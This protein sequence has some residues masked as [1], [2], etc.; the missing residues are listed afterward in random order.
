MGGHY[1]TLWRCNTAEWAPSTGTIRLTVDDP[2]SPATSM[3]VNSFG[4]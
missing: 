3:S 4:P 1:P 2:C